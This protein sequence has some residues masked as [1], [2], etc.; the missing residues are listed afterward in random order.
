MI[1][2]E[3]V[4]TTWNSSNK[5]YLEEKGYIFTKYGEKINI[6]MKDVHPN[7]TI[8]IKI[9][10]QECEEIFERQKRNLKNHICYKCSR[11]KTFDLKKKK[12][13]KCGE[14]VFRPGKN[15][16]CQKCTITQYSPNDYEIIN[17]DTVKLF[18]RNSKNETNGFT[19]IDKSEL[20]KILKYKWRIG[21]G[22][23]IIGGP[24]NKI[25]LHRF[26]MNC[27]D[28]MDIDHL[29]HNTF[30]NRKN[31]LKIVTHK[32]N[33]NNRRLSSK[34][35]YSGLKKND[36]ANGDG[37]RVSFWTQGCPHRCKKCHNPETWN[38]NGGKEYNSNIRKEIIKSIHE[39]G[40]FKNLS[41]LGGEPL[42]PENIDVTL[43]VISSVKRHYPNIQI[44]LWTGYTFEEINNEKTKYILHYID[45][46]IDGKYEEDKKD[47]TLK[48]CG[49]TNQRVIDIKETFKHKEIRLYEKA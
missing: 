20:S 2:N 8:K 27:S 21:T 11:Q 9:K 45:V 19:L 26:I 29:N 16:Y 47:I 15:D 34:M 49:S 44:W 35:R 23:Y 32:E 4:T 37:I 40:I 3:Y 1:L 38:Y 42:C 22:N 41:I 25:R 30:D 36:I 46:L 13:K 31:N 12:C 7:S 10:C 14:Y 43:D 5:K 48:Y 24:D 33:C 17:N 6:L 39:N 28:N 18:L